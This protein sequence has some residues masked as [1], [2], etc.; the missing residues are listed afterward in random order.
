MEEYNYSGISNQ[1][2]RLLEE[3]IRENRWVQELGKK[4]RSKTIDIAIELI[5]N[6]INQIERAL[7][8]GE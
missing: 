4:P 6:R 3:Y 2:R 8:I 1:E 7:G 5:M